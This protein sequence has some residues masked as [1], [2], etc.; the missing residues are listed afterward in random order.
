M[1]SHHKSSLSIH[2]RSVS[3]VGFHKLWACCHCWDE[4][5]EASWKSAHGN[6]S[7]GNKEKEGKI[8]LVSYAMSR[9]PSNKFNSNEIECSS[10]DSFNLME[11]CGAWSE[12]LSSLLHFIKMIAL[13]MMDFTFFSASRSSSW[14]T[15]VV[16][17]A[18]ADVYCLAKSA[19]AP[20]SIYFHEHPY[21]ECNVTGKIV[22]VLRLLFLLPS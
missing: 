13:F 8:I 16:R 4:W 17:D 18:N 22:V 5:R 1:F 7:A 14:R 11:K 21:L 2:I 20:I 19:L 9:P 15:V 10:E 3:P 12:I 6:H